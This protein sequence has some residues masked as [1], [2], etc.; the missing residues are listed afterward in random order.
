MKKLWT[1]FLFAIPAF[2]FCQAPEGTNQISVVGLTF[3]QV[4]DTLVDRGYELRW[5]DNNYKSV[6]TGFKEAPNPS[7][8]GPSYVY[9]SI[10]VHVKGSTALITAKWY[11]AVFKA[12]HVR[13]EPLDSELMPVTWSSGDA[14]QLAFKQID[15][16]AKSFGKDVS[17]STV[18]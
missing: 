7:G 12:T 18:Q 8:R 5:T 15:N 9:V 17:Y 1:L 10:R 2:G 6:R 16:F 3:S 13:T 11:N 14:V 4:V